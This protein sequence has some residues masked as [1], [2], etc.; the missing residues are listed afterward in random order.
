MTLVDANLLLYAYNQDSPHHAVA[1]AWLESEI[2]SGRPV[3][4]A[5]V[6][7]LAFVRIGSDNRVFS[8]PLTPA[9][10]CGIVRYWLEAP[11]VQM[12]EPGPRTWTHLA[13]LCER[14]QARAALVM[15]A[16]LAALALEHGAVVAS[17]DRDFNRFDGIKTINPLLEKE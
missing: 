7:L 11:N 6:S 12:L 1:R 14:G 3:R 10:A 13:K 2:S 8:E 17:T 16:H 4:L 9:E 15:D 5:L